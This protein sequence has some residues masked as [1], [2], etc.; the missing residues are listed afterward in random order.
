VADIDDSISTNSIQRQLQD[1]IQS[2]DFKLLRKDRS[3]LWVFVNIKS[4]FDEDVK[5]IGSLNMF[6]DVTERKN[7]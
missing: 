4:F 3:P 1:N 2:Y 5:F 7:A 6:T